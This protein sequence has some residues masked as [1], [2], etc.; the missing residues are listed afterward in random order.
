MIAGPADGGLHVAYQVRLEWMTIVAQ[1]MMH[2]TMDSLQCKG[3][4]SFG[5]H[6]IGIDS[7]QRSK[8]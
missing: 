2:A 4:T 7:T 6:P 3:G 5:E 1:H 8:G